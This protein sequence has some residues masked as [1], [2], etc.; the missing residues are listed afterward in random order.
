LRVGQNARLA[1]SVSD[2]GYILENGE[3]K[4]HGPAQDLAN[5]PK[6]REAYLGT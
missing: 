6:V 4:L 1:L 5:D 2:Y 3:I